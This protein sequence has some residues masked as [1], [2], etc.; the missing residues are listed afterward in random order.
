M[1]IDTLLSQHN[2]RSVALVS[3]V[4]MLVGIITALQPTVAIGTILAVLF[5]AVV[6]SQR[7]PWWSY[8]IWIALFGLA[9]WSYGFNNVPLIRP[10][11]LVDALVFLA[12]VFSFSHWW[13]L[14]GVPVVRKLLVLLSVL[15]IVVILRLLVDIPKFGLLA[16]RDAL[17][18]F[19]LWILLPTI[20]LGSMLGERSINRWMFW[21]FSTATAWFLLY[22]WQEVLTAVSPVV[23]IQRPVPLFSFTTAGFLSVVVFFW[24][25][26]YP[27][28][29]IATIGAAASLLILLLAQSRGAYLAFLGTAFVLS[30]LHAGGFIKR[31]G[32]IILACTIVGGILTLTSGLLIGRLDIPVGIDA[33]VK[34][35][36]T[37]AGEEGPGA[38]SFYHRLV[39]W[40]SVIEQVLSEPLGPLFGI[41]LGP[42][43]FQ[44]FALGPD[45]LV[46]KPHNDFLEIWARLGV[47]GLLPWLGILSVL[48][49]Q[50]IKGARKSLNHGWVLALQITL[51]ITSLG[52]PAMGFAYITLL[53]A[54]LTG[55][56]IGA[57]FRERTVMSMVR[58][59]RLLKKLLLARGKH[60]G[61]SYTPAQESSSDNFFLRRERGCSTQELEAR[62]R[63]IKAR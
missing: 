45:I 4:G 48:L 34:Q 47:F 59:K 31:L 18:A 52:Q 9:V 14:R 23:G 42:D 33:V 55:L 54:G 10:L 20:A 1:K 15:G 63:N 5:L 50:A 3:L 25:I 35:L 19:E 11:P 7:N 56:W 26:C 6:L 44:G 27:R 43:L 21:L 36:R 51:W 12:V 49:M 60:S 58:R 17:F 37:L 38:G 41:G 13:S 8:P 57:Y 39:A 46:R 30:L 29:I 2:L 22:P 24:F 61:C 32:R 62:C 53:W 16:V 28:R 40:P